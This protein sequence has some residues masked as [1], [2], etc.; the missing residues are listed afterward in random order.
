[1]NAIRTFIAID[2][3]LSIRQ[4]IDSIIN[5]LKCEQTASIRWVPAE[6]IHLTLKFLGDVS[7]KNLEI[8]TKIIQS[9]VTKY[10][11][12]EIHVGGLGAY[13]SIRRPRVIWIGVKAPATLMSLQ[14]S[15]ES[16]T[17]R[18]GYSAE[19]RAFSPHL[20][21]GRVSHNI[22]Q[23]EVQDIYNK[24]QNTQTPDMGSF[25]VDRVLVFRSDLKPTG[26]VYTPL[27]T[28]Y[29]TSL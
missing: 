15:I 11:P 17:H 25:Q 20:T 23:V 10:H 1:M 19:D 16:E 26:A 2:L 13:P 9:E 29:L 8:L 12:F 6:N 28:N 18:L 21:I 4:R 22:S 24:L 27:M 14:N 7:P 5:Q 3:P